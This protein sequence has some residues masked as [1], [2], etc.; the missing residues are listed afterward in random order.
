MRMSFL[1]ALALATL[2]VV[3]FNSCNKEPFGGSS[4]FDVDIKWTEHKLSNGL[5]VIFAPEEGIEAV[6]VQSWVKVGSVNETKGKTGLAHLFEHLMFKG[7]EK[8][9]PLAFFKLLEAQGSSVN[10]YTTRDYTV[11]HQTL[12][13]ALLSKVLEMEAD[14][15]TGLK[16]TEEG[17][18]TEKAIVLEERRNR[19][20]SSPMAL[21]D[22]ELW[23]LVFGEHPYAHPVSGL[24]GN[25]VRLGLD[26]FKTFYETHYRPENIVLVISGGFDPKT[27]LAEV[28]KFYGPIPSRTLKTPGAPLVA[29]IP[30]S[31]RIESTHAEVAT[32]YLAWGYR[33]VSAE[34]KDTHAIDVASN[35]LFEGLGSRAFKTLVEEKK[36]FAS[37]SAFSL[38]PQYTGLLSIRGVL[39]PGV[40]IV[41]AEEAL[42]QVLESIRFKGVT[43][44]EVDRAVMQLYSDVIQGLR[45][46][47]GVARLLGLVT[48]ILGSPDRI[49]PDLKRYSK[50]TPADVKRVALAYLGPEKK[51]SVVYKPATKQG[52]T[53]ESQ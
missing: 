35:I 47:D 13:R 38:T 16:L 4:A 41:A 34:M 19:I 33:T 27:T 39:R 45:T 42:D 11:F 51:F 5:R 20:E 53:K 44:S 48:T 1:S 25:V 36:L 50:V 32:P 46:P 17:I 14:R 10:A 26:D 29:P 43:Q 52:E 7:T 31:R 3:S 37:V 24:P 2:A 28:K 23:K 30:D 8:F 9:A 22:E 49:Q 18:Q 6:S 12:P 21:L 15:L 40:S